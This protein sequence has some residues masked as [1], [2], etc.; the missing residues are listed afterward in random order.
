LRRRL[1]F[2]PDHFHTRHG[3]LV[4]DLAMTDHV[5]MMQGQRLKSG[6][7][8]D[9]DF[10]ARL[11]PFLGQKLPYTMGVTLTSAE[12]VLI[13]R[14]QIHHAFLHGLAG[15]GDRGRA[16]TGGNPV[17]RP[18][19]P[20]FRS[21]GES[22]G[23]EANPDDPTGPQRGT[24]PTLRPKAKPQEEKAPSNVATRPHDWF[25]DDVFRIGGTPLT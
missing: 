19:H 25:P 9:P 3:Q 18:V 4:D 20:V 21:V 2:P 12:M 15:G 8:K 10:R 5:H 17:R 14:D 11:H 7:E 22:E 16:G 13:I 23:N 24:E 1:R 6:I